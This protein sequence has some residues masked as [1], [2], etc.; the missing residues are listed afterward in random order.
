[1]PTGPYFW[2][3]WAVHQDGVFSYTDRY[4]VEHR[5]KYLN[6]LNDKI[7]KIVFGTPGREDLMATFL[8]RILGGPRITSLKYLNTEHWGPTFEDRG[9]FF[10]LLCENETGEKFVVEVQNYPQ[11]FY[12]KRS[13]YYASRVILDQA[14]EESRK[15]RK[16]EKY[17]NYFFKPVYVVTLL[18]NR[19][20]HED[21]TL[22]ELKSNPYIYRYSFREEET[23]ECL[24]DGT[25]LIHVELAEFNKTAKELNGD[26][27]KW[28]YA[29]KNIN[30]FT[31]RPESLDGPEMDMLYEYA[32]LT[33]FGSND[34][35]NIHRCLMNE[36]DRIMYECQTREKN[37]REG[38][39]EGLKIGREE[40]KA[41]GLAEGRAEGMIKGRAE[42][43]VEGR[44]E[45]LVEGRAEGLAEGRAEGLAKG[46]AE[47]LVEGRA[48]GLKEGKT[49]GQI[50][51]KTETA[52]NLKK[53][54]V[55]RDTISKA[56]GLPIET[57]E[58]L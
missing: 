48:E 41:L 52:R 44:A 40:G 42:G 17:W 5:Y 39:E 3:I 27:D 46:R 33:S 15:Q 9:A 30:K 45:G 25:T 53:L 13:V 56:T 21:P 16:E 29:L 55:D 6:L 4:G 7:F 20:E 26:M 31:E 28:L 36:N 47:G 8:N 1:M 51:G 50:E 57:I 14:N 12:N 2:A 58:K 32:K 18:N 38:R 49:E 24:K 54:G 43:L 22:R 10:D 34:L 11:E 23:K 37:I 35:L 19:I